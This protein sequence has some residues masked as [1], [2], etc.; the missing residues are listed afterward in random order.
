MNGVNEESAN[1]V[2]RQRFD[3]VAECGREVSVFGLVVGGSARRFGAVNYS[4]GESTQS[5]MPEWD[6]KFNQGLGDNREVLEEF[7]RL[8]AYDA[9]IVVPSKRRY[10]DALH[11]SIYQQ[12]LLNL[13]GHLRK[14]MELESGRDDVNKDDVRENFV[15]DDDGIEDQYERLLIVDDVV[16]TGASLDGVLRALNQHLSPGAE[17]HCLCLHVSNP[18]TLRELSQSR[19]RS[20]DPLN[21]GT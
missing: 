15:F 19:R 20:D 9:I 7:V 5:S 18:E 13:S 10:A 8:N 1:A 14:K 3:F 12:G 17:V 6:R 2:F 4:K 21:A 16:D 11:G